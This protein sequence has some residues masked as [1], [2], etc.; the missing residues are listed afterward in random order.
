MSVIDIVTRQV[1]VLTKMF[2]MAIM[3]QINNQHKGHMKLHQ[4]VLL[5]DLKS[6]CDTTLLAEDFVDPY[7]CMTT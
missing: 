3:V 1:S 4:Y 6:A 7:K 2:K 5:V